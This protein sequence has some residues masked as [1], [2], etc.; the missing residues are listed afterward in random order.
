PLQPKPSQEA[1]AVIIKGTFDLVP[2]G[3]A[4][5][6]DET[7]LPRGDLH[8]GDEMMR[9]VLYP[10]DF[11]IFK[12]RAD[13]TLKGHAY[14]PGGGSP[15]AQVRFRFGR[16]NNGFDRSIAVFGERRWQQAVVRLGPTDARPFQKMPLVYER[17]YGGPD[18]DR[19]PVGL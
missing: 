3:P 15:A 10:T 11:A 18:L 1:R 8:A 16:K 2:D 13:V 4:K 6:R 5:L 19:N 12:P 9:S 7:E 17:A 14:A